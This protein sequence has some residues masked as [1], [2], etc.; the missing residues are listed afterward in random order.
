MSV[1]ENMTE[2]YFSTDNYDIEIRMPGNIIASSG[3]VNTV[4]DSENS[5]G[6]LWTVQGDYFLTQQYEMWAES[7]VNNYWAWI[8]T[9]LFIL[10]VVT[11]FV[12]RSKKEK[13]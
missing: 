10:F 2:P 1:L 13:D 7:Q 6:I 5:T 3:Y 4:P 8:I 11:G 9:A 12:I